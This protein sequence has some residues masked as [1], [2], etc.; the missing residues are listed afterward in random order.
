MPYQSLHAGSG[1]L[2][3]DSPHSGTWYP[4][5]FGYACDL[6]D[7]RPAE[8]T[9]VEKLWA[10]VPRLEQTFLQAH[11][12]RSYLDCNRDRDELD[13]AMVEG[14]WPGSARPSAKAQLGVGL[15]WNRTLGGAPIYARKLTAAEIALRIKNCWEPYHATLAD[16]IARAKARHGFCIHVN[17]HSM[18]SDP[19]FYQESHPGWVPTDFVV[20]DRSGTTAAPELTAWVAGFLRE[21]GWSVDVNYPYQGVEL[22]RRHAA[23]DNGIHSI[24]LEVAR[25]LYMDERTLAL[26]AG[27]E[28]VSKTLLALTEAL[29]LRGPCQPV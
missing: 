25:R 17:C 29:L 5:D 21:R 27:A 12:A 16:A 20:G 18:P 15:V 7:L 6:A 24:Q 13:P 10:F 2:V 1:P 26:H 9:H 11:F 14:H 19:A 28:A 22:L 3:F 4:P 23:P 8:D